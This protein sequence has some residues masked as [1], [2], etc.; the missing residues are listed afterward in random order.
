MIYARKNDISKRSRTSA[1]SS[2]RKL[3]VTASNYEGEADKQ[4]R[5]SKASIQRFNETIDNVIGT[6]PKSTLKSAARS[7]VSNAS[8]AGSK[9][10]LSM[11]SSKLGR[12]MGDDQLQ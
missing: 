10:A 4:S 12:K 6:G 1:K 8:G 11:V 7:V 3:G 2:V 5:L 9:K